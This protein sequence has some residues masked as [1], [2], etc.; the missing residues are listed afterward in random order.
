MQFME[1]NYRHLNILHH[2][3]E[4]AVRDHVPVLREAEQ[5]ILVQAVKKAAPARI[6]EI[7]T[8]IGYSTLLLHDA[9][10]EAEIDTIE[11][12]P[13]RHAMAQK[14]MGMAGAASLVHCHLG[15]AADILPSLSGPYDFVFLDGP[16]GQYLRELLMIEPKL[17]ER[18]VIAADNVLFRGLVLSKD[19]IPHRYRTI[20]VRLREYL[21]Y[22][23][24]KYHTEIYKDGDGLAISQPRLREEI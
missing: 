2:L 5:D 7:G 18:A 9:C 15:D 3:K 1:T 4:A 11:L 8:A 24:Q 16:K 6:L 23:N 17:S 12:D 21:D 22:V 20:A 10:L 13:K 14:I 19:K